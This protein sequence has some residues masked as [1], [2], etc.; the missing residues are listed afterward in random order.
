MVFYNLDNNR[1]PYQ[2]EKEIRAI[3]N[4]AH[5]AVLGL[6]ETINYPNLPGVEGYKKIRDRSKPGR[7]NLTAYVKSNLE[8][9]NVQWWDLKEQ[10]TRP[11]DP[12]NQHWPRSI[13][14][15]DCDRLCVWVAHQPPKGTDNTHDAQMEGID[16]LENRMA[17]WKKEGYEGTPEDK[18]RAKNRARVLLWD[19]NR[20]P[21]EDG[22]G[23]T[24]LSHR[25]GDPATVVGQKIDGAVYRGDEIVGH[26]S[27]QYVGKY[28]GVDLKSDHGTAFQFWLCLEGQ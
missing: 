15:F 28:G 2:C 20:K 9:S 10:W 13:L 3:L 5:P 24:M 23:P 12:P 22:P 14:E 26:N 18:E 4:D 17:P 1:D 25:I 19:A 8:V 21:E 6:C 27:K 11:K 7:D 16:K